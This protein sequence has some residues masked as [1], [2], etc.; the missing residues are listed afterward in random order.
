LVIGDVTAVVYDDI[1]AA[2]FGKNLCQK[3]RI[4]LR[5]DTNVASM[6]IVLLALRINVD[7]EDYRIRP[8]ISAPHLK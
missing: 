5:S 8:K 1:H 2:H 3:F 6:T 4:G 7:P